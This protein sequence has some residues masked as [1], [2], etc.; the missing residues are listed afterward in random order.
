MPSP[1]R[2]QCTLATRLRKSSPSIAEAWIYDHSCKQIGYKDGLRVP[3]GVG[4][5]VHM[6]SSLP[7]VVIVYF[8]QVSPPF[9]YVVLGYGDGN[10]Y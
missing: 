8:Y 9:S 5:A 2:G 6:K 1:D 10:N 4:N 3:S 7:Q